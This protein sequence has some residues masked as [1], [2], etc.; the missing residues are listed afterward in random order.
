MQRE[1]NYIK[2]LLLLSWIIKKPVF[3]LPRSEYCNAKC[4]YTLLFFWVIA[5]GNKKS[6]CHFLQFVAYS[7]MS[8][9]MLEMIAFTLDSACFN[10]T[11]KQAKCTFYSWFLWMVS[12]CRSCELTDMSSFHQKLKKLIILCVFMKE[13]YFCWRKSP[14]GLK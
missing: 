12:E 7:R 1:I 3:V 5:N 11:K 8:V 2:C 10:H 13:N 9:W 14:S 4:M 6:F